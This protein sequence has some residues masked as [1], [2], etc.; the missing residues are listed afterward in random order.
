MIP[1]KKVSQFSISYIDKIFKKAFVSID[2]TLM[3]NARDVYKLTRLRYRDG[4][5]RILTE[6]DPHFNLFLPSSRLSRRKLG[7]LKLQYKTGLPLQ[8]AE[9]S[10]KVSL[11]FAFNILLVSGA[12]ARACLHTRVRL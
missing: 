12:R 1:L 3:Y 2:V 6:S 4:V 9:R 8:A 11:H 7:S 5:L 10:F